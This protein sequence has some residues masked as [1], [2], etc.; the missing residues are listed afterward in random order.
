MKSYL[1]GNPEI[2]LALNEDLNIG[3]GGRSVY[4]N[5]CFTPLNQ[6]CYLGNES[7]SYSTLFHSLKSWFAVPGHLGVELSCMIPLIIFLRN[8]FLID[9]QYRSILLSL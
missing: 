8:R 7:K 5:A 1:S 9:S 6:H 3:R 2:R 4:G